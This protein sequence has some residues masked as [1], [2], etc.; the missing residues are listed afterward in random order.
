LAD[1]INPQHELALLANTIDWNYFEN[2]FKGLYS[3]K[4]SRPAMP[5]RFMAGVL[6]L[7]RLYNLRDERIP[8][9][10]VRDVYFQYFCGMAFSGIN[11]LVIRA[12]LFIFAIGLARM[13]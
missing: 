1:L 3:E 5:I 8:E 7:K 4:P 6:M 10:W 2:E 13:A 9:H 11:F 12:I